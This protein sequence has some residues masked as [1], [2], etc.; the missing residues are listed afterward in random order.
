MLLKLNSIL[1]YSLVA[2]FLSFILYPSYIIFLKKI[3]AGKQLRDAA[4]TGEQATIFKQLHTHKAGTP[5]MGGGLILIVVLVL[6]IGSIA[7]QSSGLINNSLFAREETYIILFAFFSMGILGL[8]DDYLNIR[9]KR[10]I[11]WLT[12]NIKFIRMFLFSGFISYRFYRKLG[13]DYLN[14]RPFG[15]ERHIGIFAPLLMFFFTVVVVNAINITDGLDWLVGGLSMIILTVL[16]IIT[17]VS[18]RYLATTV[19]GIVLGALLAFLWFNINPA[20]IF[21]GD[22]GALALGWLISSLLYLINIRFGIVFPFLILLL[23]FRIEF[24]S[25]FLQILSKKF[26][27][28]KLFTVAPFHHLLE[29]KGI[30]EHT[31]VMRFRVIQGVLAAIAL[32]GIMYQL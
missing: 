9:W 14:L 13:I 10:A 6:V 5:T 30:P 22:S 4:I 29:Y 2:F 27:K 25:S 16:A 19:I 20:A 28:R 17:F 24:G 1:I 3:K 32:I 15:G 23:L 31:I 12:A 7:I 18:Q 26:F 8:I 11:K 21:M